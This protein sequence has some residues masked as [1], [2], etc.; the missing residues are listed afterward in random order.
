VGD[1]IDIE[2][3]IFVVPFRLLASFIVFAFRWSRS[4]AVA[5]QKTPG[6]VCL[7]RPV[8]E[9]EALPTILDRDSFDSLCL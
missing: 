3:G 4:F 6:V 7:S 2:G 8:K 5:S 1:V 9:A